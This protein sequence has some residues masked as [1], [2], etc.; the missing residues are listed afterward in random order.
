MYGDVCSVR[1]GDTGM[2]VRK[3]EEQVQVY[4]EMWDL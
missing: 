2:S 3:Q 4:K 1:L